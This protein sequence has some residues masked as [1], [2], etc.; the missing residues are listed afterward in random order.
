MEWH[1]SSG[2][3]ESQYTTT[4]INKLDQ[5][6]IYAPRVENIDSEQLARLF[7]QDFDSVMR[8]KIREDKLRKE[9]EWER[10]KQRLESRMQADLALL[11]LL[12]GDGK[13]SKNQRM[14]M[15]IW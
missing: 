7:L 2:T 8:V 5:R 12:I 11:Y 9:E 13:I 6:N 15:K 4:Y 14:I 1:S 3:K 10:T